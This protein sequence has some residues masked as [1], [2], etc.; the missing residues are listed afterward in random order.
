MEGLEKK[1]I[2][3]IRTASEMSLHYYRKPLVC[4]YSGQISID[5]LEMGHHGNYV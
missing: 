5:D 1:S 2:E 3:R 4:T